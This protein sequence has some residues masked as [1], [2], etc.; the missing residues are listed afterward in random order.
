MRRNPC[1][2]SSNESARLGFSGS[3]AR[4]LALHV[5]LAHLDLDRGLGDLVLQEVQ[6][7][8][9]VLD[10]QLHVVDQRGEPQDL[11]GRRRVGLDVEQQLATVLQDVETGLQVDEL[12]GHV[13]A[14]DV[15]ELDLAVELTGERAQRQHRVVESLRRNAKRQ[16][17]APLVARARL[18]HEPAVAPGDLR[19]AGNALGERAVG[20]HDADAAVPDDLREVALLLGHRPDALRGFGGA[21]RPAPPASE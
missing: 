7:A 5:A 11:R 1:T 10:L 18:E 15:L 13:L 4:V 6:A 12:G 8:L 19:D 17:P 3:G 16:R 2:A 21:G 20:D 9:D 14:R